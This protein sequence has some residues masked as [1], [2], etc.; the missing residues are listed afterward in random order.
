M[1][2]GRLT[3]A[4]LAAG[5]GFV[6]SPVVAQ[7]LTQPPKQQPLQLVPWQLIAPPA[8]EATDDADEAP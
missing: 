6:G 1:M 3:L 4:F 5:A 2:I 8:D 7:S